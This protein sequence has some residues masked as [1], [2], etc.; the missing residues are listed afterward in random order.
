MIQRHSNHKFKLELILFYIHLASY[1]RHR[2]TESSLISVLCTDVLRANKVC[3]HVRGHGQGFHKRIINEPLVS[4]RNDSSN[5]S[6]T[7]LLVMILARDRSNC[8]NL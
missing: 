3:R 6:A 4:N 1:C 8:D 5:T 7:E 2:H